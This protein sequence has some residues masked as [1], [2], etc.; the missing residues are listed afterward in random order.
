MKKKFKVVGLSLYSWGYFFL[1]GLGCDRVSLWLI[2]FSNIYFSVNTRGDRMTFGISFLVRVR[3]DY[4]LVARWPICF[5]AQLTKQSY[6]YF[7]DILQRIHMMYV[8][9][10]LMV[11]TLTSNNMRT[12]HMQF[13]EF[14]TVTPPFIQP[15]HEIFSGLNLSLELIVS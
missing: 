2:W 4:W 8:V 6:V 1:N 12:R 10:V 3:A 14:F 15:D 5:V 7:R 13:L 9:L 11:N